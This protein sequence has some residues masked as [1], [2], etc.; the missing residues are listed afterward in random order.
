[1]ILRPTYFEVIHQDYKDD[2][3]PYS[4][5]LVTDD[6]TPPDVPDLRRIRR[7]RNRLIVLTLAIVCLTILSYI[8][9]GLFSAAAES[10]L[11]E[12]MKMMTMLNGASV[13]TVMAIHIPFAII[14]YRLSRSLGNSRGLSILYVFFS[15]F[16]IGGSDQ[17]P[18]VWWF[19]LPLGSV[20]IPFI[21]CIQT[22]NVLSD[23]Q[24]KTDT[25]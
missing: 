21:L 3:N 15:V 25:F 22:Q 14:V 24:D 19:I 6:P 9:I 7:L 18:I 4:A 23:S 17:T 16:T 13:F 20:I 1:M 11:R 2:G 8:A 10:G 12:R 5:T